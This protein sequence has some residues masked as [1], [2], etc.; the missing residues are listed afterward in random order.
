MAIS[1]VKGVSI[2]GLS[3]AVPKQCI[4]A[5]AYE[6][7][8]GK[9]A[10]EK[11]KTNTG[12]LQ[13]HKSLAQQT[14]SDLGYAAAEEVIEKLGISKEEIGAL[15]FVS[16]APDYRKP[17]TACVLQHRLGLSMDCAA[18]DV[19]LGCSGFVYGHQLMQSFLVNCDK[20]YGLL[21]V[22]ENATKLVNYED[23]GT[24]MMFGDA[25]SAVIYENGTE[26]E[27]CTLLRSDGNR[28][29]S[30]VVPSGSFRDMKPEVD[31]F[32]DPE[33]VERSKYQT[34]MN[35][36]DVFA[37]SI[38]DVPS[39]IKE[40]LS[41]MGRTAKDYDYV[42]LHQ[43][44][45]MILKQLARRI[46]A[47]PAKVPLSLDRYGNTGGVTIPLTLCDALGNKDEGV[48]EILASGFGIGLSW[49]VTS[50]KLDTSKVFPIFETD[51]EYPDG[52][53]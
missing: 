10:I 35:G 21:I 4:P 32:V 41:Y 27:G 6:A 1:K 8:F 2:L 38:T 31:T 3:T 16:Q 13:L 49:G 7:K 50:F 9:E 24:A 39:A 40:Y 52:L 26:E 34:Y 18:F 30:I 33:G 29:K 44:N 12:I 19:N 22:A 37:F 43:A 23:K 47:D 53:F 28:F 5:D 42:I 11:F 25:G 48:V 36:M 46:K 45:C 15:I 17:A 14:A 51:I 20:K